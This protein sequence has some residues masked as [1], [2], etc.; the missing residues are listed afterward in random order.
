MKKVLVVIGSARQGRSA[1]GV[2]KLV[3][4]ELTAMN[5]EPVM[6]DLKEI[7]LPFFDDSNTPSSENYIP[8][9]QNAQKWTQMVADA[10]GII[11]LTPEYNHGTSAIIKN[12]IDWVYAPFENKPVSLI[13]YG[14]GGAPF[15]IASLTETLNHVKTNLQPTTASLFFMK[16][17]GVDGAAMEDSATTIKPTL[18]ELVTTLA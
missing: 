10:D 8:S 12:A 13:G 1:D 15:A 6:A 3:S 7:N 2:A 11:F 4:S 17:I 5:V 9:S 16:N 18:A 14:W